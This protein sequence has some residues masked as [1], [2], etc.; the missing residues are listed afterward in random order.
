MVCQW[1]CQHW[2]I[3]IICFL[4]SDHRP[5]FLDAP[6]SL[7]PL[8]TVQDHPGCITGESDCRFRI[9]KKTVESINEIW[10]GFCQY[11]WLILDEYHLMSYKMSNVI[12]QTTNVKWQMSKV[13]CHISNVNRRMSNIKSLN[14]KFYMSNFK[15]QI[16]V[17]HVRSQY[18]V[19]DL[20]KS[21]EISV[22][23]VRPEKISNYYVY[24]SE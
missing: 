10:L 17:D 9:T 16:S 7:K 24:Q 21:C 20:S 15:S 4:R 14:V 6:A 3:T 8:M 5:Q 13:K 11:H 2:T 12:W 18:I 22:D 1:S 19:W 23:F